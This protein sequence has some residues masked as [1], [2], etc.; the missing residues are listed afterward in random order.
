MGIEADF[1]AGV[2]FIDGAYSPV[3]EAKI[4]IF[5]WGLTRSDCTYDVA[6]VWHGR[7]FRLDMHLARFQDSVDKLRLR[8]PYSLTE[9]EEIL[10]E[11][12]RLSGLGDAYVSMNCT[13]GAP[14]PGSRDPRHCTNTFYCYAIPFVW[15]ATTA[16]QDK[17][18][19]LHVSSIPR[20]PSQS[21]DPTIKNFHWIDLEMSLFEAYENEATTVVLKDDTGALTEGP[22]YNI[23]IMRDGELITP[24]DGMLKGVT[25]RTVLDLCEE[26][27][28]PA[29]E[30]AVSEVMLRAAEEVFISSTA[31]GIMPIT[32]IDGQT[33]SGGIPGPITLRLRE[34]YWAKHSDPKWSR[35]VGAA[36]AAT[37]AKMEHGAVVS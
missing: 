8:L 21:V 25:R 37:A 24:A 36:P 28:L 35:A 18:L 2:A 27:G 19:N 13:R 5:D 7:F 9:I 34:L 20:I 31:G 11:C 3:D 12:V 33:V 30:A 10:G 1:S 32:Q 17:G 29:K 15:I 23:F 26:I 14:S 16:E 6:H 22:G 4:S